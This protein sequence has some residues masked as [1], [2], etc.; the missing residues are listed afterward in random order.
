[1]KVLV[2]GGSGFI[3]SHIVGKLVE[4]GHKVTVYDIKPPLRKD[5]RFIR[6][7]I[8]DPRAV[9]RA[10]KGQKIIF[11]I[12]AFSNIDLVKDDPLITIECNIQGTANVLEAA[13]RNG[14]QRVIFA[15]SVYVYGDRG[16]LYT[17]AKVASEMLCK[18]YYTLYGLP[19]TILRFGTAYGPRSR[20]ADVISIFVRRAM[21]DQ[22]LVINGTG[23][24]KRN[25]IYVEDIAKGCVKA[26]ASK[27]VNA[28][29]DLKSRKSISI[30]KLAV[31]IN[32]LYKNDKPIKFNRS[33]YDDHQGTAEKKSATILVAKNI[34]Q[35]DTALA[36]GIRKYMN[37]LQGKQ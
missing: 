31:L 29:Y 28:V 37:W 10:A 35:R 20:Q 27:Y 8:R 9:L 22:P 14:V 6:G 36:E 2:T 16:H 11:H 33:R 24:Q 3:G 23:K 25:F 13:R 12:A 17:T 4:K 1:M 26:L 21:A 15:S 32:K 5:V 18:D 34:L 7:E 30:V 19:Y